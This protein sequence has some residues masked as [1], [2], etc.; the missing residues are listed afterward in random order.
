MSGIFIPLSLFFP[1][2]REGKQVIYLVARIVPPGWGGNLFHGFFKGFYWGWGFPIF[3]P[4][5][6]VSGPKFGFL[7][8][9]DGNLANNL[10]NI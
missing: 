4:I 3:F 9:K 6:C 1:L 2:K 7:A 5:G 8:A 10:T